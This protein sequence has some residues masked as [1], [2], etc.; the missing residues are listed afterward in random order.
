MEESGTEEAECSRKVVIG[1]R[2]AIVISSLV[3]TRSLQLECSRVLHELLLMPV[4]V[5]GSETVIWREKERS[6]IRTVHIDSLRGLLRIKRMDKIPNTWIRQFCGVTKGLDER[7]MNVFS[8]GTA[9]WKEWSTTG[10]LRGS[11]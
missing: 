11:V 1:K 5:Y 3:N 6:R 7:S 10:L 9:M 8:D 2:V 4:L